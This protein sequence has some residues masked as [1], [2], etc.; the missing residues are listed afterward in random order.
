VVY[1]TRPVR[2]G[3]RRTAKLI[4]RIYAVRATASRGSPPPPWTDSSRGGIT[5]P[6]TVYA[7]SHEHFH[8]HRR[9]HRD[10]GPRQR[11]TSPHKSR[12][13]PD[14]DT[15]KSSKPYYNIIIIY[16]YYYYYYYYRSNFTRGYIMYRSGVGI[17][18]IE[19]SS[20]TVM[21]IL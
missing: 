2:V 12:S 8:R 1:Y 5:R 4:V 16:R 3:A 20:S 6:D 19:L 14:P 18:P 10:L 17:T 13:P 7:G 15:R 9:C 11:Y 21:Y